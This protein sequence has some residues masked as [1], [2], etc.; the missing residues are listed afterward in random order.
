MALDLPLYDEQ[1]MAD[2]VELEARLDTAFQEISDKL[3]QNYNSDVW[4]DE[5]RGAYE[6]DSMRH[7]QIARELNAVRQQ[8]SDMN[9]TKPDPQKVVEPDALQRFM[10]RGHNGLESD[11]IKEFTDDYGS[12]AMFAAAGFGENGQ[13]F[14]IRGETASDADSGRAITDITTRPNVIS[15]LKDFGGLDRMATQFSTATGNELRLP[16]HDDVNNK[17]R[18]LGVQGTDAGTQDLADFTDVSFYTRTMTSRGID[19][20]NEAIQDSVIDLAGYVTSLAARRMGMG[21][22]Q[23]FTIGGAGTL[24]TNQPAN[25]QLPSSEAIISLTRGTQEGHTTAAAG[26]ISYEDLVA[27]EYSIERAYRKGG[28]S[29]MVGFPAERGGTIGFLISDAAERALRQLKDDDG[30]PLWQ[31]STESI[32]MPGQ[33]NMILGY[34]YQVSNTLNGNMASGSAADIIFGNFSYYAIR[35][36]ME[37]V[38][39]RFFDSTTAEKNSTRFLAF[40]R[41]A[42]RPNVNGPTPANDAKWA[43]IEQIKRM[44]IK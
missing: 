16:Q 15:A 40:S 23:V 31:P 21:W 25:G 12:G 28:E 41:R 20:T 3:N 24:A 8:I 30:R 42:G 10:R 37:T 22:D 32:A 36:T 18:L 5:K 14:V 38:I 26:A 33:G 43:G 19:V 44:K 34:P 2:L 6:R 1:K 7:A 4:D 29:A 13:A 35:N 27:L 39:Y 11:E 9:L 17:G